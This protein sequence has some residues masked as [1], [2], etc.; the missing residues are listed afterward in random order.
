M[1]KREATRPTI[2]LMYAYM[3]YLENGV[4][5]I[6]TIAFPKITVKDLQVVSE[7]MTL[8]KSS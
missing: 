8:L 1:A 3:V 6:P 7:T 2:Q 4:Y 5:E